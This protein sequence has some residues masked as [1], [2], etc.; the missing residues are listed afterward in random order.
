MS[1]DANKAS[2]RRVFEEGLNSRRLQVLDEIIAPTYVNHTFPAPAPGLE[3]FKQV[4][5]MFTTA[6]PDMHITIE[7]VIADGDKVVTRGFFTGTHRGAFMNIPA[8][9]KSVTAHYIDIWQFAGGKAVENWV[10]M[11]LLGLMR[12][13]GAI[14]A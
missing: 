13:L 12:Q 1:T 8:T 14:P 5:A 3:G 2:I 11:D 7:D 10:Q 4:V 9:G 6:F